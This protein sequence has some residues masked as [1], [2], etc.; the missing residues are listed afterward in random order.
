LNQNRH[1]LRVPKALDGQKEDC[2]HPPHPDAPDAS[3]HDSAAAEHC[4]NKAWEK[5]VSACLGRVGVMS[6][7]FNIQLICS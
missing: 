3:F 6:V 4:E 7:F 5:H 1:S 2:S